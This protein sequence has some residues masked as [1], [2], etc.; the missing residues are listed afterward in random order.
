LGR[1]ALQGGA[2]KASPIYIVILKISARSK[3]EAICIDFNFDWHRYNDMSAKGEVWTVIG[4]ANDFFLQKLY[5]L[6]IHNTF[7]N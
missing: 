3:T 7:Y 5:F 2:A 6:Q 1:T 4:G